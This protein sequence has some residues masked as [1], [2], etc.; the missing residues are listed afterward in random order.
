MNIGAPIRNEI[1]LV[2]SLA[3]RPPNSITSAPTIA[4]ATSAI[5]PDELTAAFLPAAKALRTSQEIRRDINEQEP[6]HRDG[7]RGRRLLHH[8]APSTIA[9]RDCIRALALTD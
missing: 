2:V 5:R 3:A 8:W 1:P 7:D 4:T 9:H 6:N